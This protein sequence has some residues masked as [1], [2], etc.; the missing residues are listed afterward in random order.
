MVKG[1]RLAVDRGGSHLGPFLFE[2]IQRR[3]T[4]N[5]NIFFTIRF[6]FANIEENECMYIYTPLEIFKKRSRNN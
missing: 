3:K 4:A 5:Q 1:Q 2:N 6:G